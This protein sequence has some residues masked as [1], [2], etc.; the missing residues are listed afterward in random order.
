M[1]RPYQ[2]W[3]SP[4]LGRDMEQLVFGHGGARV[5]AFP[6]CL[7]RFFVG[8]VRGLPPAPREHLDPGL[9]PFLCAERLWQSSRRGAASLWGCGIGNAMRV[10]AGFADAWPVWA[11]M[12]PLYIGGHDWPRRGGVRL[13]GQR[14]GSAVRGPF[15]ERGAPVKVGL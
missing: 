2:R 13:S 7:G 8:E 4:S 6:T 3:H 11:K 5:G 9:S 1:K 10:W 12:R 15:G 14:A